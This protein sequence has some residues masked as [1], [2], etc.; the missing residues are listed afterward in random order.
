M[1]QA[2][3]LGLRWAVGGRAGAQPLGASRGG[4]RSPCRTRGVFLD[5]AYGYLRCLASY[6]LGGKKACRQSEKQGLLEA[7]VARV[8]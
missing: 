5:S 1:A 2:G 8:S 3:S 7:G 6:S 4:H